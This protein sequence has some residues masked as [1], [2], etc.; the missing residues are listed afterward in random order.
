MEGTCLSGYQ[1]ALASQFDTH[2]TVRMLAC[3]SG[4]ISSGRKSMVHVISVMALIHSLPLDPRS[5]ASGAIITR[6]HNSGNQAHFS[7]PLR[8]GMRLQHI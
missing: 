2:A 7:P 4:R 5:Q 1:H 3:K 8:L 6:M